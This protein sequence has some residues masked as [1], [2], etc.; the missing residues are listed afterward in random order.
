M[1]YS[2]PLINQP[3]ILF[4]SIGVGVLL[5]IFYVVL[6]GMFRLLGEGKLSYYL[7][8][9]IFVVVFTL[10]SFFFMV[11]Y[12]EGR[13]RLHLIIGEGVG[14]F[15]IYFS[16]GRYIYSAL[17]KLSGAARL[18]LKPYIFIFNSFTRGM[19]ALFGRFFDKM[20]S[21]GKEKGKLTEN[22]Q[23][24]IKKFNLFGKIHLKNQDKSV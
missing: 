22:E 6:Q 12:N 8:D 7:S 3:R 20:S 1:S 23:K 2:Q 5:G 18:L 15:L 19:G 10:V 4:F 13:V 17:A 21:F 14:F 16:V 11:L 9:A 24:R